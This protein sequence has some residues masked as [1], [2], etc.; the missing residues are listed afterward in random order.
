MMKMDS[1][2]NAD[3]MS[4]SQI[5]EKLEKGYAD[6]ESGNVLEA[7]KAFEGFRRNIAEKE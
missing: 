4:V 7:V 2:V 5:H 1:S 6:I 3:E